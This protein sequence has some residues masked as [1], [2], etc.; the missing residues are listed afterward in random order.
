LAVA[1]VRQ[2][3]SAALVRFFA[4]RLMIIPVLP[5]PTAVYWRTLPL[6]VVGWLVACL[7][8]TASMGGPETQL[9]LGL[10]LGTV[11]QQ[12][13]LAAAWAAIGPGKL[14]FRLP[15][16]FVWACAMGAALA[17]PIAAREHDP[18][19][20]VLVLTTAGFWFFGQIPVWLLVA[21]FGVRLHYQA[22]AV[23]DDAKQRQF[24]IAQ[25]MIFTTFVA[26][27]LG[28][29]RWLIAVGW[30]PKFQSEVVLLLS[31]MLCAQVL[32]GLPLLFGALLKRRVLA[33][34]VLGAFFGAVVTAIEMPLA[35][36]IVQGP[37]PDGSILIWLNIVSGIWVLL[38]AA[39]VRG[40]GYQF[41]PPEVETGIQYL[42]PN[43]PIFAKVSESAPLLYIDD[44]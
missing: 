17:L 9:V 3:S 7:T 24:G 36:K 10:I 34:C 20:I 25:L 2:C 32:I 41:G 35:Y 28:L 27:L 12:A 21:L 19:V 18:S 16:S 23:A 39:V 11:F 14:L 26:A 1:A 42:E 38:F 22:A 31:L 6:I 15:V 13:I 37:A 4:V 44:S 43:Q 8:L 33:G 29:G 40:S 5:P 30:L